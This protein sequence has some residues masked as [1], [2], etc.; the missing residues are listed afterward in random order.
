MR[1]LKILGL[2]L[3]AML[4]MGALGASAASADELTGEEA[5][6]FLTGVNEP[7]KPD[8][9]VTTVG[10]TSCKNV[11]YAIGTVKTPTTTVTAT[12]TYTNCTS[13]GFPAT[14]DTNGCTYTFHVTGGALTVGDVTIVCPAG[15]E[16]RVTAIGAGTLKCTVS[17]PAQTLSNATFSDPVTYTNIGEGPTRGVTI[18]VKYGSAA[19]GL[20]Y[21]HKEGTGVGKC[22]NGSG[23]TG[24]FEGLGI[25]TANDDLNTTHK[26]LFLT[27]I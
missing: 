13:F 10:N 14:I 12:P 8:V 19:G 25:V 1:N 20:K 16:I 2:A 21:S 7:E 24:T 17:V 18:A 3:V 22:T 23:T 4:A 6:L 27:A 5:N 26:G 11:A 15:Q 9:F